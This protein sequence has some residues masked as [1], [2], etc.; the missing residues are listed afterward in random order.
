MQFRRWGG[1]DVLA[2]SV[3]TVVFCLSDLI[4]KKSLVGHLELPSSAL[5][6]YIN[7]THIQVNRNCLLLYRSRSEDKQPLALI[8]FLFS[9]IRTY[10]SLVIRCTEK[11]KRRSTEKKLACCQPFWTQADSPCLVS[12]SARLMILLWNIFVQESRQR[13]F[14][15]EK[16]AQVE[17]GDL[18]GRE[19]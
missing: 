11:N 10:Q 19:S 7:S 12:V 1:G 13:Y 18:K 4:K 2:L 16:Q 17:P 6:P 15:V 5:P 9:A 3:A 14:L 8:Y